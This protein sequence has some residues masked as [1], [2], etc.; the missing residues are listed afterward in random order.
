MAIRDT[1]ART[2]GSERGDDNNKANGKWK[3]KLKGNDDGSE[4]QPTSEACCDWS[5]VL[6]NVLSANHPRP[7]SSLLPFLVTE[8][9][10]ALGPPCHSFQVPSLASH[11]S[12]GSIADNCNYGLIFLQWCP[13]VRL[14]LA[15]YLA[16]WPVQITGLLR[17]ARWNHSCIHTR[18][19]GGS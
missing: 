16:Y 14:N 17:D 10:S 9:L 18:S 15:L 6:P 8:G 5:P 13:Q 12:L 1:A 2:T 7:F 19:L 4:S 11:L 3:K